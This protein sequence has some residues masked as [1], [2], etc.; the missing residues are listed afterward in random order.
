MMASPL[1]LLLY[2][3]SMGLLFPLVYPILDCSILPSAGRADFLH[4]LGSSMAGAGVTLLEYRNKT[5][6]DAEILADAAILRATLPAGQVK[7]ILDDRAHLVA[8]TGFDGVHVD[9]GDISPAEARK[10]LG[11]HR[12]VGTYGG[13]ESILPGIL[14]QPADYF[15]IGPISRTTTKETAKPPIGVDGVRRLRQQAGPDAILVAAGGVTLEIAPAVLAA[16]ANALA[17][18]AAIFRAR[19]P[20]QEFRRWLSALS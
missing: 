9:A 8:Q 6:P 16:G 14:S 11:S 19:D 2:P 7:L 10:L 13:T 20:A 5:G 17:A 12:I 1:R 15:S 3:V 18:S 4:R